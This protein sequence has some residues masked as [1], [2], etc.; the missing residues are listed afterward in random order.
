VLGP[1]LVSHWNAGTTIV[2]S[3]DA[4]AGG[5]AGTVSVNL[6]AGAVWLLRPAINLLLEAVWTSDAEA[7]ADG[8]TARS[9]SAF[10]SPGVR[11]AFDLGGVQ[12]VPGIAYVIGIGPSEGSSSVF[13][14]LSLEHAFSR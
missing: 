8:V 13:L 14:Y 2:P 3:A 11:G 5:T 7:I 10:V 6:G 9:R 12:V 1:R 4:S